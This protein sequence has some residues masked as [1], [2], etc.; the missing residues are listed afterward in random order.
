VSGPGIGNPNPPCRHGR[1]P[2][3]FALALLA[4]LGCVPRASNAYELQPGANFTVATDLRWES[5]RRF[6]SRD[7]LPQNTVYAMAQDQAGFVYAGTEE[8]V[9]RYDGRRWQRVPFPA[10]I[11]AQRP[12]INALAA[13]PDG[14][15]WVGTDNAGLL[16]YADGAMQAHP[17]SGASAAPDVEA[18][19]ADSGRALWVGTSK[20]LFRC[21]TQACTEVPAARGLQVAVLLIATEPSGPCLYVGTNIDGLYRIDDPYGNAVRANWHL[22]REDGLP[23]GAI[24]SLAQW[25]G[26]D[27]H[28]L[29][30]GTGRGLVRLAGQR[31]T[32]YAQDQGV[33]QGG[34][35]QLVASVG[36]DGSTVLWAA[37]NYGGIAEF[38]ND[39]HWRRTT[40]AN[41][42]P[43]DAV[44]SLLQTDTDRAPP[45]L[46][47]GTAHAG[48]ARREMDAWAGFD[49]RNGLPHR[50]VMSIGEMKFL[51]GREAIWL[52]SIGG[53][54]RWNGERWEAWLPPEYADRIVNDVLRDNDVLWV[55][56]ERGLL[57]L[58]RANVREYTID[59]SHLPGA[60]V[61]ALVLERD[62]GGA[63]TLWIGTHHGL[64]RFSKGRL[65]VE[66]LSD[67]PT[68][69][70]VHVLRT[71]PAD[72]ATLLWAG[73][74]SGLLYRLQ[75]R[76]QRLPRGCLATASI[77]DL[78]ERGEPGHS[79]ELWVA[80]RD[81]V[82]SVDLDHDFACRTL[83]ARVLPVGIVY[84]LQFDRS[85]RIYA[86][87]VDG[88][89]R[90][91][92]DGTKPG[93]YA[94]EHFSLEDG[95]S[96]L[97]F[98]RA[99][100]VDHAGRIWGG[101]TEGVVVYDPA[102]EGTAAPP[103]PLR[104][105][106]A[107]EDGRG[108]ALTDGAELGATEND[109]AFD[110]SLLS[111]QRDHLTR[112]KAELIGLHA[113]AEDWN[114]SGHRSYSRLPP[115]DYDFRARARDGEGVES[116]PLSLRFHI[117]APLWRQ[118]WAMALYTL[119]MIA[120]GLGI[121]RLRA[122]A[123]SRRT[124]ALANEVKVRTHSLAEVNRQLKLASL[125]DPLTGLWNR[126]YFAMEMQPESERAV[127]R[128][129]LGEHTADVILLL[130]DIDHFKR[131]N[132]SYGH[133]AGDA[134]LIEFAQRLNSLVRGG[135]IAVRWGGEE[136]LIVLRDAEREAAPAFAARV[137]LA[138][139][140]AP[141]IVDTLRIAI[142]C[143][144]GWAAFPF[145]RELPQAQTLEQVIALADQAL[146]RAKSAGRDC[147]VG[148]LAPTSAM[149]EDVNWV[150]AADVSR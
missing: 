88:V 6:T 135:D 94:V 116:A 7:G 27:G 14:A 106:S 64:A 17:L 55:G 108:R 34:V 125:T 73:T 38:S 134:A 40:R 33:P 10:D 138:I 32:V 87:G 46:W 68:E 124:V 4:F 121:G 86:F 90:L 60:S 149:S 75:G 8:G 61:I 84:Q 44:I 25:G 114:E 148:A 139:N 113:P 69:T 70:S 105:L 142:T 5:F 104:L 1:A 16:R 67:P 78:R 20:G 71:T 99:S 97:E 37:F 39:G 12:F 79:H 22:A 115:G 146:Y 118:P 80:S 131:V 9:A 63:S 3:V 132:D 89:T 56:T 91:R 127:R 53:A 126:R 31:M 58:T 111:Y 96:G 92:P 119:A 133:A 49:E 23:N 76:W 21:D 62:A 100:L 112:Y 120:F 43:D 107:R 35:A 141:F 145:R 147:I 57:Q 65:E 24:R 83:D 13:T 110:F 18:I 52:G 45:V 95:L 98:N 11:A 144:I 48:I 30:V 26:V 66:N 41:G 130:I 122:Q 136:F 72:G 77:M 137:R 93:G 54:V 81:G 109:V 123:L 47:L 36:P 143:S 85:D 19:L 150:R 50:V 51:D 28:D 82:S 101:S 129:H 102:F 29:W 117:D 140:A 2:C 42:L 59:N 128:A 103:R 15:L 74:D